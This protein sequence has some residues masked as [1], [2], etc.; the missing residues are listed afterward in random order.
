MSSFTD[1]TPSALERDEARVEAR[2]AALRKAGALRRLRASAAAEAG[3]TPEEAVDTTQEVAPLPDNVDTLHMRRP[4]LAVDTM[5]AAA[6]RGDLGSLRDLL[7]AELRN[8]DAPD[9]LGCTPLWIAAAYGHLE[10][11]REL[12]KKGANRRIPANQTPA[13]AACTET[14]D[15]THA[16]AIRG[17]LLGRP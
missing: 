14:Y 10:L 12:V 17:V 8:I 16:E 1:A 5:H 13:E 15:K 11:V 9:A 4:L 2:L 3:N 7:A 6:R